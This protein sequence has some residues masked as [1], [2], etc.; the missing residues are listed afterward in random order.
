MLPALDG[1]RWQPLSVLRTVCGLSADRYPLPLGVSSW[2]P[3]PPGVVASHSRLTL[4]ARLAG[5]TLASVVIA[6]AALVFTIA[7]FWW[8]QARR[9]RLT[10]FPV[11]TF[12]GYLHRDRAALRIPLSV[13]NSGAVPLVVTDLRLRLLPPV[14]D[15]VRMHFR[16]VRR[17]VR[18][19][20]DDVEDFSHT[21]SVAGRS[22][23]TRMVEFAMHGSPAPL[24]CG[25]PV[26]AVVEAQIGQRVRWVEL[27]RF[28]VHV[29][30]MVHPETTSPT[31]TSSTSG[32]RGSWR[33][34]RR[35]TADFASSG[36]LDE[37]GSDRV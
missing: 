21:Y 4:G 35:P 24:L 7:S 17:T 29:E 15:E 9:G 12:S 31:A 33:R 1:N 6:S 5:M 36:G 26:E 30:T 2:L 8:L 23:D 19:G 22:V 14:G 20:E 3:C 10:C 18:P 16:T 25:Q 32:R 13:F 34:R 27:G 11:Q 28:P 37:R